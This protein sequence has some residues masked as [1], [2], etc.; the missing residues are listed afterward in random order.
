MYKYEYNNTCYEKCPKNTFNYG[1]NS[2]FDIFNLMNNE[3]I[4]QRLITTK[5]NLELVYECKKEDTLNNNCGF[6]G[7]ENESEVFNIIQENINSLFDSEKGKSQVIKGG[8]DII[9]QLTNGKNEKELFQGDMINN[10][11]LTILDLGECENKLKIEYNID[12]NDSLIYL[13]KENINVKAS[14]K[15]VQYEIFEPHNFTKLN[16]SICKDEKINIYFPLTL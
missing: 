8:N 13:K 2:C 15:D 9:Y 7:V 6:F 5:S 3:N 10:Q 4:S 14:E 16:L 11:N 1:N 12:Y